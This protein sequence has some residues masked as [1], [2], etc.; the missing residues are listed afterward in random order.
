MSRILVGPVRFE[1]LCPSG[2]AQLVAAGH[3]VVLNPGST[4]YEK[5]DLLERVHDIDAA[6]V[7]MDDWDAEVIAAAPSLQILS[8][9]GVGVDN[10]D[11][12]SARIRGVD[13]TNAPG[14]NANA[15]A[16]MALALLLAAVRRIPRQDST[17]RAGG[18]DRFN[19]F[20]ITGSSIGLIGFGNTSQNLARR[21]R[22]FDV[23]LT[24]CD[25]QADEAAASELGVR[26]TSLDEVLAS[27]H[28]VSVHAPHLPS[29]HHMLSTA[30]FAAMR[31]GSVVVNTSRGGVIDEA[32]LAE[33]LRSGHLAAA[34]IDVWEEEPVSPD[35]PL[36]ALDTVVATCHSAADT[37]E[38]YE[39]V[40]RVV[41]AAIVDRLAGRRPDNIRTTDTTR[42]TKE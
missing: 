37:R 25:P 30:E 16:E 34:G 1:T 41:C 18:W 40:G 9:L 24:A 14:A 36:L 12:D 35:H 6:I 10:I 15:V 42:L 2:Y 17:V 11:L 3:D 28:A 32:A 26:L 29:T 33:A 13:V 8:K 21:L 39:Q 19:G 22:G 4:P 7:G 38:A 23:T 20:E 27:S 31:P 5:A